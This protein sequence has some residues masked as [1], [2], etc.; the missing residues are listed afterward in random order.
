[1]TLKEKIC[2]WAG[3]VL[4][5]VLMSV[6]ILFPIYYVPNGK[7]VSEARHIGTISSFVSTQSPNTITGTRSA[8]VN[9]P[10]G[11]PVHVGLPI[12]GG[13]KRG[14]KVLIFERRYERGRVLFHP[15]EKLPD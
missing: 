9:L 1:M 7:L 8:V 5:A 3:I 10:N 4:V 12:N 11:R 14:D 13:F 6:F 15:A 2:A